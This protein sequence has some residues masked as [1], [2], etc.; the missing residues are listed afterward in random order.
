VSEVNTE[1]EGLERLLKGKKYTILQ[2]FKVLWSGWEM[3]SEAIVVDIVGVGIRLVTT[4][5][6]EPKLHSKESSVK[7]LEGRISEYETCLMS[8]REAKAFIQGKHVNQ[9]LGGS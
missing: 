1:I 6:G 4:S 5:H 3:D 9:V 2:S 7:F 8:T